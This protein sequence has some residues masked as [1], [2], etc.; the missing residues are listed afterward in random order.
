MPVC[1][2]PSQFTYN[3]KQIWIG[4][5]SEDGECFDDGKSATKFPK[6]HVLDYKGGRLRMIDTPGIADTDG[7]DQDKRNFDNT[8]AYIANIREIHAICILMRPNSIRLTTHFKYCIGQL[9][10]R[11]H[12]SAAKNIV[13]CFTNSRG[14]LYQGGIVLI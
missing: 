9:L 2:I 3:E 5:R 10:T 4:D 14:S 6:A 13:F 7:V 11:L 12:K 1:L 8:L